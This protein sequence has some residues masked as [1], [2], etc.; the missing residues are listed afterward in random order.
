LSGGEVFYGWL[1]WFTISRY[2]IPL[3]NTA[4]NS[5]S[6]TAVPKN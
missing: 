2:D 5:G 1:F 3:T 6:L 4:K